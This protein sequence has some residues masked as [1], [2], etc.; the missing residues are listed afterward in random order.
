SF[1][2][3]DEIRPAEV[4]CGP[5]LVPFVVTFWSA[6][7]VVRRCIRAN[8]TPIQPP[9]TLIDGHPEWITA[10][11]NVN[12]RPGEGSAWREQVPR[13]NR[14]GSICYRMNSQN[15]S[16]EIIGIGGGLL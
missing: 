16:A 12:F 9:R 6:R 5:G 8:F 4:A 13:R 10:A 15:L 1:V 14:V 3:G 2:V 7:G 11:H